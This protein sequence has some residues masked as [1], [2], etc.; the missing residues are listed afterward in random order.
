M[1]QRDRKPVAIGLAARRAAEALRAVPVLPEPLAFGVAGG[2]DHVGNRLA[3]EYMIQ[4]A[5][6]VCNRKVRC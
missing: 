5:V 3:H 4:Q 1:R 6:A 2:A